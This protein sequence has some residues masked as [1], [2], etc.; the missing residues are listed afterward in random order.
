MLPS[1]LAYPATLLIIGGTGG[2]IRDIRQ[3]RVR[4]NLVTWFLWS[5]APLIPLGAQLASGAG[6][7]MALS[8]T[9]GLCPLVVFVA[10]LRQGTFRLRPF[11]W[12]CAGLAVLALVLWRLTGDGALGVALSI[13]ADSF[14]AAPTL[15]KTYR[16]P[17]SESASFFGLFAASALL[18][19]LTI[20][21][22][23]I[24]SS[25][26]AMYIFVLYVILFVLARFNLGKKLAKPRM[27]DDKAQP[28]A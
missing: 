6:A 24:V 2:Y 18:T 1:W 7:E 28:S 15:R 27:L 23:S 10:S 20:Q 9:V 19:L 12:W 4:P 17:E 16:D 26:F 8:A 3:G 11:D 13:L 5:L 21:K 22:W 14:G 25:A